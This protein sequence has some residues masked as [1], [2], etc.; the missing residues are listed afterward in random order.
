[1][2][3]VAKETT[4]I[5]SLLSAFEITK[6]LKTITGICELCFP[7]DEICE[8]IYKPIYTSSGGSYNGGKRAQ[9]PLYLQIKIVNNISTYTV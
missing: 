4:A 9:P 7:R 8:N 3:T 2:H 6:I 1:M 5:A